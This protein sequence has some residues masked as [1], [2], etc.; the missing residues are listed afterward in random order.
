MGS[1]KVAWAIEKL[2]GLETTVSKAT[3]SNWTEL[4][5]KIAQKKALLAKDEK[6]L[7]LARLEK[8]LLE[9]KMQLQK[10]VAAKKAAESQEKQ[11]QESAAEQQQVAKLLAAAKSL[12]T[13]RNTASSQVNT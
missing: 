2:H 6:E 5:R 7:K 11:Q 13:A 1:K 12:A 8:E 4:E 3:G 10:L 9:K